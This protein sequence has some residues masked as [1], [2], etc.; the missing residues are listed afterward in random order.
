MRR[1]TVRCRPLQLVFPAP[2]LK[3]V[4]V[5]ELQETLQSVDVATSTSFEDLPEV[6]LSSGTRDQC[7]NTFYDRNLRISVIS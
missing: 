4:F 6:Q 7:Y 3:H 5:V 2:M 1:S